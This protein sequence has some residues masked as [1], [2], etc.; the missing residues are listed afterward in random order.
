MGEYEEVTE[1]PELFLLA[2]DVPRPLTAIFGIEACY[3]AS[4]AALMPRSILA[5]KTK[6]KLPS[7]SANSTDCFASSA[8]T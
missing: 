8:E 1:A 4:D 2:I 7:A 5:V 3:L 6:R